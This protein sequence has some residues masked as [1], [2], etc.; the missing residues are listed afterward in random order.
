MK[1]KTKY[2]LCLWKSYFEKGYGLTSY[3]KYILVLV[4]FYSIMQ[5]IDIKFLF[6]YGSIYAL[7]CFFL[8]KYWFKSHFIKAEMEVSNRYNLFV[9]EMRTKLH[10]KRML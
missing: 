7:I 1:F 9:E 6:L 3:V 5:R 8:G 2:K 4:G 10:R